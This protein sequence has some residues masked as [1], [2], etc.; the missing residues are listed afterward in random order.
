MSLW[1]LKA[2]TF[3]MFFYLHF[4]LHSNFVKVWLYKKDLKVL[5]KTKQHFALF[6]T[7]QQKDGLFAEDFHQGVVQIHFL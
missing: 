6:L 7:F 3:Y 1:E 2:I 5:K 4:I